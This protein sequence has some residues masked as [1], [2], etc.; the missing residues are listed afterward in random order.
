MIDAE[1]FRIGVSIVVSN[2]L[3]RVLWAKR[4][5]QQA[6]QF[7]QGGMQANETPELALY[8]ELYEEIGLL[9]EDVELLGYTKTWLGYKLPVHMQRAY[10][11]P[12]CIGQK[13]R[14]FLLRLTNEKAAIR[15]DNTDSPEFDQWKWV[16]Y[17]YPLQRV[18][19][20]KRDV[21]RRAL[22]ELVQLLPT[23]VQPSVYAGKL[24]KTQPTNSLF[25]G[26][27]NGD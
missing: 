24:Q 13:Q 12:L 8:R 26:A 6:W 18:I 23:S 2:R 25:Q 19:A 4:I 21:Y 15:F 11:R 1:G 20:F 16:N 5:R 22:E 3:N 27:T 10:S 7:P 9:P 14:W 17:W